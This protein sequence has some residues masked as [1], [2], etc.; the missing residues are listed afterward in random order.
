MSP[1]I[2]VLLVA[3]L[4]ALLLFAVRAAPTAQAVDSV[5]SETEV[6]YLDSVVTPLDAM[7]YMMPGVVTRSRDN[8]AVVLEFNSVYDLL[9]DHD[10]PPASMAVIDYYVNRV[11][12][13]CGPAVTRGPRL[14]DTDGIPDADGCHF[15][16][17]TL[18]LELA[19]L[20]AARGSYP[21]ASQP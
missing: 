20:Y 17:D 3:L 14:P 2:A 15:A 6:A 12:P 1:K 4:C 8:E 5:W 11:T 10:A 7:L 16:V 19:R 13:L 21:P 18:R 9:L